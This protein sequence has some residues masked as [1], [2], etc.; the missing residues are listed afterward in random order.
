MI[1]SW[2]H[3]GVISVCK[4]NFIFCNSLGAHSALA[5]SLKQKNESLVSLP[6]LL[7]LLLLL[8]FVTKPLGHGMAREGC[9]QGGRGCSARSGGNNS[10]GSA[11]DPTAA[12]P[13][14]TSRRVGLVER[15]TRVRNCEAGRWLA[16]L[17]PTRA[18]TLPGA[19]SAGQT[20]AKVK[21]GERTASLPVLPSAERRSTR[22]GWRG[23]GA[24]RG[25]GWRGCERRSTLRWLPRLCCL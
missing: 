3:A 25:Q 23:G 12:F 16:P 18:R 19:L 20:A 7:L 21:K 15:V 11:V 24:R 17:P 5:F 2:L 1:R 22:I 10:G 13:S 6:L 9:T 8:L 4:I 14:A